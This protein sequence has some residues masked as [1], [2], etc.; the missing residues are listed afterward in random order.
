MKN[1]TSLWI[2]QECMR[3]WTSEGYGFPWA[4]IMAMASSAP[5]L[6]CVLDVDANDFRMPENM[7]DAIASYCRR[8]GQ[9]TPQTIG[10]IARCC[11]ESLSLKYRSV[12][13]SLETLTERHLEAI[14]VVGGGLNAVLCQM[15]ADACDRPVVSGPAE[16]SAF[17][18]IMLQAIATGHLPDVSSGRASIAESIQRT[19]YFP[20]RTAAWDDDCVRLEQMQCADCE[21]N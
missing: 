1:L 13:E 11:F 6:E 14:R 9:P 3:R 2:P 5:A 8:T 4:D 21:T 15:T 12:L 10:A 20:H 16:A 19:T 7:P 18:N 17:G